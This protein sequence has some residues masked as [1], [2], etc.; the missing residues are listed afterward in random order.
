M[1]ASQRFIT[2]LFTLF[3][4]T[5]LGGCATP[6]WLK[7]SWNYPDY[8]DAGFSPDEQ[9]R[10]GYLARYLADTNTRAKLESEVLQTEY[11]RQWTA[12]DYSTTTSMAVDLVEGQ[13]ASDLGRRA[14]RGGSGA[15]S[16]VR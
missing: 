5:L 13:V 10:L 6:P 4:M 9:I 12:S 3:L 14:W 16:V 2:L 11:V 1:K 15:G 7:D 8:E